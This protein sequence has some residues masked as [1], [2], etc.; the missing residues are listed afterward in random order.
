M[1]DINENIKKRR[2]EVARRV[3]NNAG[4]DAISDD[5]GSKT[6]RSSMQKLK[7]QKLWI[8]IGASI[9]LIL[10]VAFACMPRKGT[11]QYG[12]CK[13]YIEKNIAIFPSTFYEILSY[14][15]YGLAHIE[16]MNINL[17]G[18]KSYEIVECKFV[19]SPTRGLELTEVVHERDR[20]PDE[21]IKKFNKIIPIIIE[22]P[23]DLTMPPWPS[24]DLKKLWRG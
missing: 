19:Q 11:I 17:E 9:L 7:N 15:T 20:R 6:E 13:I 24:Y 23:P 21:E 3:R 12:I 16:Y 2:K 18:D 14:E 22:S 5:S 8:G 1:T 10:I 4:D